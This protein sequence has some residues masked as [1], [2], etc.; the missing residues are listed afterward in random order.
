MPLG[1]KSARNV[2]DATFRAMYRDARTVDYLP[3]LQGKD[4]FAAIQWPRLKTGKP[5]PFM[6][7][8]R[9][10]ILE[11][12]RQKASFYYPFVY[13][14]FFTGMRPSEA[15]ALRWGDIGLRRRELSISKSLYLEDES[16]AK[17]NRSEREIRF[18]SEV[19]DALKTT[20]PLHETEETY[21]FLNQEG[22]PDQ[23]SDVAGKNLVPCLKG[24]GNEAAKTLCD[25]PHFH[26]SRTQ[27]GLN[28]KW[29]ADYCGT[30]VAMIE[31]H[32]GKYI[33][34]DSEEQL[35][36]LFRAESAT[37]SETLAASSKA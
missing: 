12:F 6:E 30:S 24:E 9:D 31:K 36:R 21:V 22:Q 1:T 7:T 19:A 23:F 28:I 16:S 17:T 33:K 13:T 14:R 2:I 20:K 32:Y 18:V 27:H 29:L 10:E 35:S 15:L 5:N 4:P 8:E 3:E 34:N 37:S 11:Y 26:I 25:A